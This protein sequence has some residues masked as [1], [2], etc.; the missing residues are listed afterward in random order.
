MAIHKALSLI[1]K[2]SFKVVGGTTLPNKPAKNTF[3][4]NTNTPIHHWSINSK[5]PAKRSKNKNLI[6][7]PY[8]YT[9]DTTVNGVTLSTYVNGAIKINGTN[10]SSNFITFFIKNDTQQGSIHVPKGTYTLSGCPNGGGSTTYRLEC[11]F[12]YDNGATWNWR[13]DYGT[14][15]TFTLTADAWI[16]VKIRIEGSVTMSNVLFTPQLSKSKNKNLLRNSS[17]TTTSNGITYT[18]DYSN[19][20]VTVN[21]TATAMSAFNVWGSANN[22]KLPAGT[23]TLH[24]CPAGGNGTSTYCLCN[25]STNYVDDGDGVTFTLTQDTDISFKIRI[26]AGV[27]VNNLRFYPQLEKNNLKTSYEPGWLKGDA[28]GQ[29]WIEEKSTSPTELNSLKTNAIMNQP[30]QIKQYINGAWAVKTGRLYKIPSQYLI[31][32]PY[33]HLDYIETTGTQYIDTDITVFNQ[34]AFSIEY[35]AA[36]TAVNY[37]YNCLWS[38]TDGQENYQSWV[39]SDGRLAYKW[40]S[41][42]AVQSSSVKANTSKH[43]YKFD[44]NGSAIK[45]LVDGTQKLSSTNSNTLNKPMRL[46]TKDKSYYGKAKIYEIKIYV[47]GTLKYH[48]VPARRISD[49]VIGLR[50]ILNNKFY[51]NAG[52]GTFGAGYIKAFLN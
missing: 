12:S 3:W 9:S 50:D 32:G 34:S 42:T 36:F 39:Y 17:V 44:K 24:G 45:M 52:T 7:Y 10:S 6:C 41:G 30:Y 27:T 46:F 29:V 49:N 33:E 47:S 31:F 51:V 25:N 37:N 28:T 22:Q 19:M 14:G 2:I 15:T 20:S 5:E 8:H 13:A 48:L 43:T 18:V 1:D 4:I 16:L 26:A 38:S 11:A 23:Y 40:G 21:G 35:V